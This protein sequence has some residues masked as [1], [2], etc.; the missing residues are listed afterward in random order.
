[1]PYALLDV[2]EIQDVLH[3]CLDG[4]SERGRMDADALYQMS[5]YVEPREREDEMMARLLEESGFS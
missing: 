3:R 2:P 1:M 5:L 4:A